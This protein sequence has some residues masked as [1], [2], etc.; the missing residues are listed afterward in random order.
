MMFDQ[1]VDCERGDRVRAREVSLF[2]YGSIL[3][4]IYSLFLWYCSLWPIFI[5]FLTFCVM[6]LVQSVVKGSVLEDS[7]KPHRRWVK[8]S[9]E[10]VDF[11]PS[12]TPPF[13]KPAGIA[14]KNGVEYAKDRNTET[15]YMYAETDKDAV[16][17]AAKIGR[18]HV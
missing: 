4:L 17:Q 6:F 2:F 8:L 7:G 18:A 12:S 13:E 5:V 3:S 9:S 15:D 14:T 11:I 10:G 16:Y 1:V